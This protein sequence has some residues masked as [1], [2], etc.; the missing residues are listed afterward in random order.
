M[1]SE[2]TTLTATP[3]DLF[4]NTPL[5]QLVRTF[6]L[7]E[8]VMHPYFA[9]FGISGSQW[10]VLRVLTRAEAADLPGL[11]L[12]DLSERLLVRPPSVT[13]LVD[14]LERQGLVSRH[15]VSDDLRVRLVSLT[16]KGRQLVQK[17]LSVHAQQ[18]E[19]VLGGLTPAERDE[20]LRL[21]RNLGGHL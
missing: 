7:L 2:K 9:R 10:G 5:H 18:I 15:G 4:T 20:L 13:T 21:L 19:T 14:R 16:D 3:A 12:T 6:G 11:R 8:R 17:V 1:P